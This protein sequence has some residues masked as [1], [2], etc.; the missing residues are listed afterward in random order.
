MLHSPTERDAPTPIDD[1]LKKTFDAAPVAM[2]LSRPDGTF[3]YVNPALLDLLGYSEEDIYRPN[4]IITHPDDVSLNKELRSQLQ[5][6]PFSPITTEKRYLHKS[7]RIIEGLLTM[8]AEPDNNGDVKRFIAQIIDLTEQKHTQRKLQIFKNLVQRSTD[9]IYVVDPESGRFLDA[10][11]QSV[12]KL[13]YSHDEILNLAVKDVEA[14]MV[15]ERAWRKHIEAMRFSK[16]MLVEGK[17]IRKDGTSFPVEVSVSHVEQEQREY[18]FV[19][20]RDITERKQNEELIWK[21]A[22]FDSLTGLPNRSMLNDRLQETIKNAKRQDQKVA[23]LSL[24]LDRFKEVNDTLG[25]AVGDQLLIEASRRIEQCVREVD[26]VARMGGDEFVI[27]LGSME[28]ISNV[29]RVVKQILYLL[30]QPFLLGLNKSY[31][32]ASIGIAIFP[33]DANSVDSL[34]RHSDQAMYA[35][36]ANGKNCHHYFTQSLQQQ[37]EK[38]IWLNQELRRS[39]HSEIFNLVYQPIVNLHTNEIRRAEALLRW[40]HPEKGNISP[41]DFIP[42]AEDNG[43]IIDLGDWVFKNV[44]RQAKQWRKEFHPNFQVTVN[45]SPVQLRSGVKSIHNW[46]SYLEELGLDGDAVILEI[47]EGAMMNENIGTRNLLLLLRDLGMQVA[48]DDFGTGYSSL[49]Y[50]KKFNIDFLKIDQSFIQSLSS[51]P[52]DVAVCEAIIVMAHK[53]N[54]RVIAEGIET[55]EQADILR[56]AGCDYGQGYLFSK[57]VSPVTL[58]RHISNESHHYSGNHPNPSQP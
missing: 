52:E 19:V 32:S 39:K 1:N 53:L 56:K 48:I 51:N 41:S 40:Q 31:V 58:A 37:A 28:N 20:A 16:R 27:V 54:L 22:N 18:L 17:H 13:G 8:V 43:V 34:L 7:G 14:V 47:T 4:V 6:N 49:S 15:D 50:L 35:A 9:C 21:Q 44:A 45:T 3:E 11:Q 38:Q 46:T 26:T 5:E 55:K 2:V 12:E 33:N 25:H 36:K 24:D 23:V 10:N 42:T 29:E 30:E 57:P